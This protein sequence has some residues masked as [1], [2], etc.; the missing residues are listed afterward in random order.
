MK[1]KCSTCG[2]QHG[3][4]P[5]LA[6]S[7]PFHYNSLSEDERDLNAELGN[8]YCIGLGCFY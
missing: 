6:F 7:S 2:K 3:E 5:S 4:W 8:D 1:Y